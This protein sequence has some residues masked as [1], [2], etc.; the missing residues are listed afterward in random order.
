VHYSDVIDQ[1]PPAILLNVTQGVMHKLK[2]AAYASDDT[3]I[4]SPFDFTYFAGVAGLHD[5]TFTVVRDN[6]ND[7]LTR[8]TVNGAQQV[9]DINNAGTLFL[10]GREGGDSLTIS[11]ANGNPVPTAGAYFYGDDGSDEVVENGSAGADD[12]GLFESGFA[13]D[14]E[15]IIFNTGAGNDTIVVNQGNDLAT[16]YVEVNGGDGDDDIKV[17]DGAIGTLHINGDA[18]NDYIRFEMH[19]PGSIGDLLANGDPVDDTISG[20]DTLDIDRVVGCDTIIA[21]GGFGDDAFVVGSLDNCGEDIFFNGWR[22][23]AD[24]IDNSD[25]DWEVRNDPDL[26]ESTVYGHDSMELIGAGSSQL[27]KIRFDDGDPFYTTL[28]GGER[29]Y[30]DYKQQGDLFKIDDSANSGNGVWDWTDYRITHGNNKYIDILTGVDKGAVMLG[31]LRDDHIIA[32]H[33]QDILIDGGSGNDT[34]DLLGKDS[35]GGGG[36]EFATLIGG[37]GEDRFTLGL[38][39]GLAPTEPPK[40]SMAGLSSYVQIYG[41]DLNNTIADEDDSL[42][43]YDDANR[44]DA[45]MYYKMWQDTLFRSTTPNNNNWIWYIGYYDAQGR[46]I[47]HVTLHL[48]VENT[49]NHAPQFYVSNTPVDATVTVVPG[50]MNDLIDVQ[51]DG[52][53]R[54]LPVTIMPSIGVDTDPDPDQ[55]NAGDRIVVENAGKVALG[56]DDSFAHFELQSLEIHETGTVTFDPAMPLR[57]RVSIGELTMYKVLNDLSTLDIDDADVVVGKFTSKISPSGGSL[58]TVCGAAAVEPYLLRGY[59]SGEGSHPGYWDGP[60]IRSQAAHLDYFHQYAGEYDRRGEGEFGL[61]GVGWKA[62]PGD[63]VHLMYARAGDTDLD[64]DVDAADL[65]N[66]SSHWNTNVNF[67]VAWSSGDFTYDFDYASTKWRVDSVD[68]ALS[69]VIPG[70]ANVDGKVDISD[71]YIVASHF[72]KTHSGTGN[73]QWNTGDFTGDH[74]VDAKDLGVLSLHWQQGVNNALSPSFEDALAEVGLSDYLDP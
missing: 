34:I 13:V 45:S 43:V 7:T 56:Y 72:D 24:S 22:P 52:T 48:P 53:A 5:D 3:K 2:L 70:D 14:C 46:R 71:L 10:F 41:D 18:G 12:T 40:G 11:Y 16:P 64:G 29:D 21:N 37:P 36:A 66:F 68:L 4:E 73:D 67:D 9:I 42:E 54:A 61:F 27:P 60:G 51:S 58:T 8:V 63:G 55:S 30:A 65:T 35:V 15:S 57:Y 19:G 28:V 26:G 74:W 38:L 17:V 69:G 33:A 50:H 62:G 32:H 49:G 20:N 59:D 44:T 23:R 31:G 25:G 1:T 39:P 47:E 6:P